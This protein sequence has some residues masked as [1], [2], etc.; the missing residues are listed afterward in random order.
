[1]SEENKWK[2]EGQEDEEE[3]EIDETAY[4]HAKDAVLFAI[5]V[6]DS[7]LVAPPPT[8]SKKAQRDTPTS[9]ALR[10]AFALMQQRIISNPND[11]M[12][13]LLY[14]TEQTK[15][16]SEENSRDTL[17]YPHCYL[18]TDLDV[19]AAGDVRSLRDL[20]GDEEEFHK[21]LVPSKERVPMSN[22]LFCANQIFTI[23]AANFA[24]RRLFIV[25]DDDDP[26]GRDKG[27][28]SAA[29]VRAKDL[30]DLGVTIELFPISV[31]GRTFD[32]S[33]FYDDIIY[34]NF[35][36]DPEAPAP[37]SGGT[38]PTST[39]DG[40]SLL[41]SLLS[42]VNS[43]AVPRRAQFSSM[44]MEIGPGFKISVKGYIIL[45]KQE[46]KRSCY[47]WLDGEKAQIATGTT[48]QMAEDTGRTVEKGEIRKA[49]KFGGEQVTFTPEE[50]A[51]LRYFGDPGIRI[52]GFK[53]ASMLPVWANTKPATFLYP[54][55]Q[56]Y[57][58]STRVF[59]A[60]QQKLLKDNLIGLTWFIP[61][62]NAIPAIASLHPGP[63]RL[64]ESGGQL[65][66]PGLW[67]APLPYADDIRQN[68]ETTLIKAPDRLVDI[69]RDVV[70]QLQLP[71]A[72]Y[73]PLKYPNP[74]L[75]WHYRIL[76]ALALEEDIPE[77]P[78]D[79]TIP[80]Y[81]QIAKR[82]GPYVKDWAAE[83]QE[84]FQKYSE[85]HEHPSVLPTKRK[86]DDEIDLPERSKK[87]K[88]S[89]GP[90]ESPTDP[91]MKEA[92]DRQK[93]SKMKVETLKVWLNGKG[94][95]VKGKKQDLIERIEEYF[96][97]K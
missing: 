74:A 80:K 28:K 20:V 63:E 83:L 38:A 36:T 42:A 5:E 66:P 69:M 7:M 12:G 71:K 97:Q 49:F 25:T 15:F 41:H 4:K 31:P 78:E 22:V 8:D 18:L 51:S 54:T 88:A 70:Q 68:P 47:V 46:P 33:K 86:N 96:E 55:E 62:R 2:P 48:A 53:P 32:R 11:M 17:S 44:P 10:C 9:A 92:F 79:K 77:K 93:L 19:P 21:L 76:Q 87:L 34:N 37:I 50:V 6:S 1:M 52:I 57:I 3:E 90:S 95:A 35:P 30:Y 39:S 27:L 23:K 73:D 26:H 82:A 40:I 58:G 64:D 85:S 84:S 65:M 72:Q 16:Q 59:A 13:V 24:S 91:E 29:T 89:D 67:L 43:K 61:R 94:L 45:K 75:Q 14:G 81:K 56:D 60:L